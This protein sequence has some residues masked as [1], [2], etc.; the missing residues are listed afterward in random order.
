MSTITIA[1]IQRVTARHFRIEM[2]AMWAPSRNRAC[3]RPRQISMTL[4]RELTV[5][6]LPEIGAH[7]GGRDHTTVLHA[8]RT[9]TRLRAEDG[10]IEAD[11]A[12]ILL[13]LT[14]ASAARLDWDRIALAI[15]G[16]GRFLRALDSA[17]VRAAFTSPSMPAFI[18]L[19]RAVDNV[20]RFARSFAVRFANAQ[21]YARL[22]PSKPAPAFCGG[23]PL[24]SALRAAVSPSRCQSGAQLAGGGTVD[25]VSG[26]FPAEG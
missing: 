1:D 21:R 9:I 20:E 3:A 12:A 5:R 23:G 26:A 7:F 13:D 8:I 24:L 18:A 16:I 25:A 15:C 17:D 19:C 14:A 11:Y 10:G 6:S 4:A 22:Y 2:D